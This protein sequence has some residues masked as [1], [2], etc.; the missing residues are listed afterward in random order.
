MNLCRVS[1]LLKLGS[2]ERRLKLK[3]RLKFFKFGLG[4]LKIRIT[5]V[6]VRIFR[7]G[8]KMRIFHT[9]DIRIFVTISFV[10]IR[11]LY[12]KKYVYE[13]RKNA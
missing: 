8:I 10:K 12:P 7:F 9:F 11:I 2:I 4:N 5:F 13:K 1:N 3:P 6:Y